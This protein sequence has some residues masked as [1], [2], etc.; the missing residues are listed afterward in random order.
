[1]VANSFF[2]MF[3]VAVRQIRLQ[4]SSPAANRRNDNTNVASRASANKVFFRVPQPPRMVSQKKAEN[5]S[6]FLKQ[7]T[8]CYLVICNYNLNVNPICAA[9]KPQPPSE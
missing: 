7:K 4:N 3:M 9:L 6:A 8:K 5:N 2:C 1:L